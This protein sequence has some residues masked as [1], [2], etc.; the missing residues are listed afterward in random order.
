MAS[1]ALAGSTGLVGGH[2][3]T[4]LL[5]HPSIASV[6][7]FTRRELPNP[8][9]STKLLPL[10]STDTSTWA[11]LFPRSPAPSVFL[12]GLGTTRA[13]AG[14]VKAQREIDLDLN[15]ELAKAA[16]DAGVETYV[17]IST[18]GASSSSSMAYP[19]MKGEL[20]E[21]VKALGFKHTV[22]LRPGLIVGSRNESRFAE[23]VAR[24]IASGLGKVSPMLVNGWAQDAD[25]IARAA[26]NAGL[27]CVE[28]KKEAGLWEVGMTEIVELGKKVN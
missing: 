26:V 24:T 23:A 8:T 1:A 28:G 27:L 13:A 7:A 10:S 22:L 20:E 15:Y 12:S 25:V 3:L 2:I 5:A 9:A 17:L 11:S 18:G 6:H 4:Q 19:K 16:K 14:S 21:K